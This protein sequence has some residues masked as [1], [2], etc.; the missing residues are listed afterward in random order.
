MPERPR[1]RV[2]VAVAVFHV[3]ERSEPGRLMFAYQITIHNT[4]QIAAQLLRRHWFID[5]A[6]GK[7]HEVHDDGVVGQ[8]PRLEPGQRFQYSSSVIIHHAP[9][10][11]R[12]Y[13]D[14]MAEDGHGFPAEIP[15]F[16]LQLPGRT[17]N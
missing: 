11:M 10:I 5:D 2:E 8:Q 14:F 17:L 7:H 1:Y 13:Y 6:N 3:P 16:A 9:G 15:A 12:G 4:G